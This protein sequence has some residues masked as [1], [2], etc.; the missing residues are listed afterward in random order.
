MLFL[1]A[2]TI[3][4]RTDFDQD[5]NADGIHFGILEMAV[6]TDPPNS[7][8]F[9]ASEFIGVQAFLN[10]HSRENWSRFCLAYRFT[11]RDFNDGVVGLAY[12]GPQPGNNAAGKV[13]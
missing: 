3:Y 10:E 7:T 13:D 5:G 1:Q 12:I 6:E 9:F 4:E 8:D 2:S 11:S